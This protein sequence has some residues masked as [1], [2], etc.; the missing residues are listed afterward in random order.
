M[1]C[2]IKRAENLAVSTLFRVLQLLFRQSNSEFGLKVFSYVDFINGNKTFQMN[3]F[4]YCTR[5]KNTVINKQK[6]AT[7]AN[8]FKAK[9][10]ISRSKNIRNQ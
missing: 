5:N 6:T 3:A 10:K 9:Q 2:E 1:W 4:G 8:S 7:K